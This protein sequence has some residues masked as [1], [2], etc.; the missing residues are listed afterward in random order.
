MLAIAMQERYCE[1]PLCG[2]TQSVEQIFPRH[3]QDSNSGSTSSLH[4]NAKVT[5]PLHY[6]GLVIFED[7]IANKKLNFFLM[8]TIQHCNLSNNDQVIKF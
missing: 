6:R 5:V 2:P 8:K 7:T 3:H 4:E 1:I